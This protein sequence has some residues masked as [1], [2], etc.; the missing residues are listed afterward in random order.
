MSSPVVVVSSE[1]QAFAASLLAAAGFNADQAR[2]TAEVLVWAD[3]RGHA[4]HGVMRLPRYLEWAEDGT[5][6]KAAIPNVVRRRGSIVTID[7]QRAIG[8]VALSMA[9]DEA[10]KQSK[11]TAV[12]W[13]LVKDHSHA[14]AVGYYA[15]LITDAG[16]MAMVMTASRPLMAYYG[17]RS[18]AVSTNPLAIGLPGGMLL[19]MSTAAI[20]KGKINA[21]ASAGRLLPEGVACDADGQLTTDPTR[22]VTILPLGGPKG[23]GLAAMIEG[24]TSLALAN[25]LIATALSD[26]SEAKDFRQNGL[27]VAVDPEA[28]VDAS[29]VTAGA[30]EFAAALKSQKRAAGFEE[31]LMPGE[32]GDREAARRLR[33]GVSVA[34]KTWKQLTALAEP[35]GVSLPVTRGISQS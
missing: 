34:M 1:L 32:R 8:P 5:I 30:A 15:R 11:Q 14:G 7:A 2:K 13:V 6:N 3:L 21:A 16:M 9:A 10:I 20:A 12:G 35:F 31:I 19:D 22:A 25:P 17:T 23:A 29:D 33:N 18:A 28:I 4:S 27:V 24:L 26:G